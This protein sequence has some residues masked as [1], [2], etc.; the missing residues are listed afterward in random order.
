[1]N[2]WAK[3]AAR[4]LMVVAG[5]AWA[6]LLAGSSPNEYAWMA[7]DGHPLPQDELALFK[8]AALLLPAALLALVLGLQGRSGTRGLRWSARATAALLVVT[9]AAQ[10]Y[11]WIS[12]GHLRMSQG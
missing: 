12:G 5:L 4:A 10:L 6:L 9:A 7:D 1:V 11:L 2:P 8:T 3:L